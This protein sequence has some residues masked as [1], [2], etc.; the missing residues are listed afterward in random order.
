MDWT[1]RTELL[2][3]T[4]KLSR[5]RTSHILV[6][7]NGGVGAYASEQVVR[8]GV[9][10]VTIIDADTVSS[11]N[12]NR[13]LIALSSTVNK[14]KC[15]VLKE[16][17]LDI[18]PNLEIR[19]I[20]KYMRGDDFE[21]LLSNTT[22]TYIIDCIDTL[23]PKVRLISIAMKKNIP[24]ISSMGAGS[25][26]DPSKVRVAGVEKSYNCKLA[27]AVRKRL[28]RRGIKKGFKVV[29]SPEEVTDNST[30]LKDSE[31]KKTVNGTI[32]YLPAMFGCYCAATVINDIINT[33]ETELTI[34]NDTIN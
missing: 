5:L 24:I 8:A 31:N 32:S 27:R 9:G 3:G 15:E 34:E 14:K 12:I 21:K 23:E 20:C 26:L 17:L 4:E 30:R 11:S 10:A 29:F 13:Q 18:N 25:K 22:F 28:H 33:T 1:E 7:G 16:R 6:V 19:A 2:I